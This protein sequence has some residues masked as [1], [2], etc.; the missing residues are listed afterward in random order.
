MSKLTNRKLQEV[1]GN[2]YAVYTFDDEGKRA[3]SISGCNIVRMAEEAQNRLC[4]VFPNELHE[5]SVPFELVEEFGVREGRVNI[6]PVWYWVME[7][8]AA[9]KCRASY[10]TVQRIFDY[11]K[12]WLKYNEAQGGQANV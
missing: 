2:L 12:A 8:E 1:K 4:L 5:A 6:H 7:V 9:K 10:L 3:G 11:A